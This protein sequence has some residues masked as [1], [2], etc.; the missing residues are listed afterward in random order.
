MGIDEKGIDEIGS[1]QQYTCV[2]LNLKGYILIGRFIEQGVSDFKSLITHINYTS[3]GWLEN[4]GWTF[5]H[6]LSLYGY[7]RIFEKGA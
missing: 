3:L 6:K 1:Y 7:V 5:R 4:C 2:L